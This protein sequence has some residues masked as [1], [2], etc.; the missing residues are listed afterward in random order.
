MWYDESVHRRQ[1]GWRC[2]VFLYAAFGKAVKRR[3]DSGICHREP[4]RVR[5][6]RNCRKWSRSRAPKRE[7]YAKAATGSPVIVIGYRR[8]ISRPQPIRPLS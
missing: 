5:A 1:V 7:M 6:G 3:V 2:L 4:G 8:T